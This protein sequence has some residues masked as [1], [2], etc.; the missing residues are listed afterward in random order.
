MFAQSKKIKYV[1]KGLKAKKKYF[2]KVST[3]KKKGKKITYS[4]WSKTKTV[5]VR[6]SSNN[7]KKSTKKNN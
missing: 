5:A 7:K 1:L 3:Y 4:K 6:K 2:I